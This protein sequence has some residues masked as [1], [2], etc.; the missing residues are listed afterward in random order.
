MYAPSPPSAAYAFLIT[1]IFSLLNT[2]GQYLASRLARSITSESAKLKGLLSEFNTLAPE[3]DKLSWQEV[4]DLSSTIWFRGVLQSDSRVPKSIK[5][6]AIAA[7]HMLLRADEELTLIKQE[8]ISVITYLS[9]WSKL[10][11]CISSL[12]AEQQPQSGALCLLQLARLKCEK[13][14]CSLTSTFAPHIAVPAVLPVDEFLLTKLEQSSQ[15]TFKELSIGSDNCVQVL[16]SDNSS[17]MT[18]DTETSEDEN[19]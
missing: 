19:C 8:M 11:H 18:T 2:D 14:L 9:D 17:P 10:T 6:E 7:H 1:C 5:L 12:Q 15:G 3:S 16:S 13:K 4:T